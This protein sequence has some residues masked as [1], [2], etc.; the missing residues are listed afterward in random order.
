MT[1]MTPPTKTA[2]P[3]TGSWVLL[4]T[5]AAASIAFVSSTSLNVA[6]PA[7]QQDLDARAADLLWV[8]SSYNIVQASLML[9]SGSLSDHY[10]R[11]RIC[12]LGILLFGIASL[13][14]GL[15]GTVDVLIA[16]R[17]AQGIGSAMLGSSSLA[18][19]SAYYSKDRHGWAIG[20]WS[21]FTLLTSGL[22][23]FIGGVL[24]ELA[25]W[26]SLFYIQ[27]PFGIMTILVLWRFVPESYDHKKTSKIRFFSAA[28]VTLGLLGITYGFTEAPQYGP[29]HPLI[30]LSIIGGIAAVV[31]FVW[32]E[33]Q[34]TD[35]MMPLRLFK[36]RNFSGGNIA[37]FLV[38]V[39]ISPTLL[40]MPLTM[41]QIHGYSETAV[42][43]ALL[44]MTGLMLVVS[45]MIGGVVDRY[46][47]RRPIAIGHLLVT[48]SLVLFASIGVSSGQDAYFRTYFPPTI[49][50]G[51]GLGIMYAPVSAAVMGAVSES[52]A[53]LASGISLTLSRTGIVLSI[54]IVGGFVISLFAQLLMDDPA[55]RALPEPAQ[56]HLESDI[57]DLAETTIPDTLSSTETAAVEQ[58]I[59]AAYAHSFRVMAWIGALTC[60]VSGILCWIF[61]RSGP[62]PAHQS[63]HSA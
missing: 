4:A 38:A 49:L 40:Y 2:N 5:V 32:R 35:S 26:R 58:A 48:T 3:R 8:Y 46:G 55:V 34:T 22:G 50:M 24:T 56:I 21:G 52:K 20:I 53:G 60:V 12:M 47:P 13:V 44:P 45:V 10:G 37:T 17:F 31:F 27:I 57:A 1:A 18:I 9:V 29:T 33:Q 59:R 11:V 43:V 36:R 6:L 41:I 42:G 28:L 16:A 63:E 51:L 61:I 23:P 54:A 15:A 14:A 62:Q 39:A 7:I 25:G 19:V 30:W